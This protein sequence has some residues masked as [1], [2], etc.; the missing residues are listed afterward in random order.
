MQV[1]EELYELNVSI[2]KNYEIDNSSK[3]FFM[4]IEK[5]G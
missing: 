1:H 3:Q 5:K 2:L 4:Y